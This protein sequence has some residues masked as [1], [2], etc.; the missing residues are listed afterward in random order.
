LR[1]FLSREINSP[2]LSQPAEKKA[3]NN[4]D[5]KEEVFALQEIFA[6]NLGGNAGGRVM[7]ARALKIF[8][9]VHF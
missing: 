1:I 6:G 5:A 7:A 8:F 3:G 2:S 9:V 4:A